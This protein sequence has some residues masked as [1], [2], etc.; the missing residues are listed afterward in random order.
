MRERRVTN[1][2]N[3][4]RLVLITNGAS[5]IQMNVCADFATTTKEKSGES[6]NPDIKKQSIARP[7]NPSLLSLKS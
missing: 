2:M 5:T 1:P 7:N 4:S 6:M 3:F